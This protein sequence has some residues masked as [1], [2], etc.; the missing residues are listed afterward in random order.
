MIRVRSSVVALATLFALGTGTTPLCAQTPPVA[1]T[2]PVRP[3]TPKGPTPAAP[4]APAT[5]KPGTPPA[6]PTSDRAVLQAAID[7][8]G[9]LD[10]QTRAEASATLRRAPAAAVVP[11]LVE[12]ARRHADGYVRF[13]ALVLLSGFNDPKTRP[14][15]LD[16]LAD[17]N[18][19][20]R[21][22]AYAYVEDHPDPALAPKL[23][24]ALDREQAE[25]V[26][27]SL[28]HAIAAHGADPKVQAV[29][30]REVMRGVDFFRS[31]VIEALG[32]HKAAYALDDLAKIAQL[33]GPL[34]DDAVRAI[35]LIGD[36]RGLP[37]LV[38]V[39]RAGSRELQ[40]TVAAAICGLGSNCDGHARFVKESLEFAANN[41]GYQ[42]LARS[43]ATAL[44]DLS[45]IGRAEALPALFALG[46][47]ANDPVR[48]PIALATGRAVMRNPGQLLAIVPDLPRQGATLLLRDAFDMLEEDY[49]EERFFATVRR[50]YWE[51]SPEAPVRAAAQVLITALEF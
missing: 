8:L 44:A 39:Q 34:Q 27:P 49:A 21:E 15:F 5:T 6:A 29:L 33:E 18:D 46:M 3:P 7:K 37:T 28:I 16:A 14:V 36:K 10:Y 25:F 12:A 13:R 20:L 22:V 31:A 19:R 47:P 23:L 4:I 35:G 45:A 42:E 11:M 30:R 43:S 9:K 38:A 1:G 50:Q 41:L 48:A 51:A 17:E 26:R 24:Q 2:Q 40:P 32:A